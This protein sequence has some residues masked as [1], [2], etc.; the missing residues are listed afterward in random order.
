M[1]ITFITIVQKLVSEQGKETL[2]NTAKCK[3]FLADYTRGEYKKESRLLVQALESGAAKAINSTH[4]LQ[5]CK[6][7]QAKHLQD[8]FPI[9]EE[10]AVDVVNMLAFVLLGDTSKTHIVS[11]SNQEAVRKWVCT[12]CGYVHTGDMPRDVCPQC[13]VPAFK[14][15]RGDIPQY[16]ITLQGKQTG[17]FSWQELETFAKKGELSFEAVVWK[18]GMVQWAV[19]ELS[20]L[21]IVPSP[22]AL[23]R[24]AKMISDSFVKIQSGTFIMGSPASEKERYDQE[25][26]QHQVTISKAF[27][28]G[29]Y[30]VTQKEWMAVMGSNPSNWKGDDLPVE[31]VSW[32]DVID[33]CNKRSVNE[34]LMPAYTEDRNTVTWNKNAIGYRLPT[35]AEWEYAC[36]AG[37]STPFSTGSNITTE[38]ANYDGNYP[39]N[40]NIKGRYLQKPWSVGSGTPNG[41]GLYDMHGNVY[42]WCWDWYGSYSS[43]V[44]TDPTGASSGSYRVSRGGGWY[45]I[46][47]LVRSARRDSNTPTYRG[48]GVGFRLVRP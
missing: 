44:Q 19:A 32:L 45:D 30:Q 12:V 47:R 36:R 23:P 16:Y 4:D 22:I 5:I 21:L 31:Q 13:K 28:M 9:S 38:Q 15:M 3:G 43:E 48:N 8:D 10:M 26:P 24:P 35:E 27:Y 39:Y 20:P 33:Y 1:D 17:P 11:D 6:L 34:G 18:L 14:F 2:F 29:K 46:A 7:Q 42:E 41:W 37:T 25:G 40:G